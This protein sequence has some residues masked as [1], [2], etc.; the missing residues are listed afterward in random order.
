MFR[1]NRVGK[2]RAATVPGSVHTDLL[3]HGLIPDPFWRDNE[4]LVQWVDKVNWEYA[5]TFA[6]GDSLLARDHQELTFLGVDTHADIFLNDERIGSTDN[7]FRAWTFDVTGKLRDGD[8]RLLVRLYSPI[9]RGLEAMERRD[10]PLPAS[11]DYSHLGG[12]GDIHVS[13][14]TRKAPY[15]YG[16]DWGPRLVTSGMWR[17]VVLEGWD[18]AR[19]DDLFIRQP[20]VTARAARLEA[21]IAW[22]GNTAGRVEVEVVHQERVIAR[23]VVDAARGENR[24]VIPFSLRRPRLWWSNGLGEPFLHEFAARVRRNGQVIAQRG[25]VTGI[26]SLRLAREKDERGETFYFELNGMPVFAKGANVI[27][28]DSFLPR[29]SRGDRERLVRDA[30]LAHMNML[31]VWGGGVYEDDDF[32]AACDRHGILVWQ[33][34]MFACAMYPGDAA[35]LENVRQEAAYNITRLRGHPCLALWCGNNE[36]DVAWARW[37]WQAA[38]TSAERERIYKEY[39]TLAH[40]LLPRLVDSL[41]DGDDYWPSSPMSGDAVGAHESRPATSGDNHYWGVWHESR[42]FR[43]FEENGG[44]FMSEYGFQSFPGPLTV[45]A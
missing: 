6:P 24:V 12:M 34:F 37:G 41:T 9:A 36:V 42:P 22:R 4:R 29:V 1:Q 5:R 30:A 28:G 21:E 18:D 7:M 40:E 17:P 45:E 11:N 26:R 15:H 31:R 27:P 38:Y 39:V 3:A 16:W 32:Y 44:S 2:W 23:R 35:F 33:D 14:Y 19:V 25:V 20:E 13:V 8:N 43:E 10:F